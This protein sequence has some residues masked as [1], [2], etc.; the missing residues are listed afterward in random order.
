MRRIRAR[1]TI[2]SAMPPK[3]MICSKPIEP[4]GC[5]MRSLSA[6]RRGSARRRSP[7]GSTRFLLS[8]PDPAAPAVQAARNLAVPEE[9]PVSQK[10][11]ALSHGDVFLLRREWNEKSKRSYTEIRAE[12]VRHAIHLFQQASSAG[13]YRIC[14]VDAAEDLNRS[15][16]NA[17]LKLIEEP[18]PR[19]LFLII[20]HR[21]GQVL[22]TIRSRCRRLLLKPLTA[23]EIVSV[24]PRPGSALGCGHARNP[25]HWRRSAP[26]APW[27]RRCDFSA[28]VAST[29]IEKS[30]GF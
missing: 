29:S 7:G 22:S 30:A 10:I 11:A 20:S 21:P 27:P 8:H 1:P 4:T 18:P 3:S 5:R 6:A 23:E 25:S 16:A 24:V 12:D 9:H 17:L 26:A 14:I 13:G 19:S 2:S 28:A 15:G